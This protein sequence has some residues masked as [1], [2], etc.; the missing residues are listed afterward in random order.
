MSWGYNY[1]KAKF[2]SLV[3]FTL[4]LIS[5][6][7]DMSHIQINTSYNVREISEQKSL[8]DSASLLEAISQPL[9]MV[10]ESLLQLQASF[11]A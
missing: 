2:P 10:Q 6:P 5:N 4:Q 3:K 1:D 11:T 9:L 8:P 7:K